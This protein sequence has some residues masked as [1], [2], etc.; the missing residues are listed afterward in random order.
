MGIIAII[1]GYLLGSIPTGIIVAKWTKGIDIRDY[2]SGST[3][4]TNVL[5]TAGKKAAV[6]VFAVDILKGI[7]SVIMARYFTDSLWWIGSAGFMSVIGHNY[8][9]FSRFKGGKGIATTLG[10]FVVLVPLPTLIGLGAWIVCV[11]IWRYVSLASITG[12]LVFSIVSLILSAPVA[13]K[14]YSLLILL[15]I[16]YRHKENIKRLLEGKESKIGQKGLV[17][18]D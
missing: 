9:I 17:K 18:T 5:R 3:G 12:I 6:V 1:I 8:P 16:I 14:F 15:P 2:G 10:V 4:A 7:L 11:A 13:Y